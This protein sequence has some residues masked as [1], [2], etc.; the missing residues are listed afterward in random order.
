[1]EMDTESATLALEK[2]LKDLTDEDIVGL[3]AIPEKFYPTNPHKHTPRKLTEEKVRRE[4]AAKPSD[5]ELASAA[6]DF[7]IADFILRGYGPGTFPA[8]DQVGR[9]KVKAEVARRKA[10]FERLFR[11]IK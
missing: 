3:L 5:E 11:G 6:L 8:L 4:L 7:T 9:Y 1:M 10:K 2:K